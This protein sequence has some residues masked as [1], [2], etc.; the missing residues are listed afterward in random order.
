M[1]SSV[2]DLLR[3]FAFR[4]TQISRTCGD[5]QAVEQL[6]QLGHDRMEHATG[7]E[8]LLV[9]PTGAEALRGRT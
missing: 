6:D 1:Q 9:I 8:R 3:Q 7:F 5:K 4:V 2:V